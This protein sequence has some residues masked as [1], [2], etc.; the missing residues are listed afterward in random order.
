MQSR[1]WEDK[2]FFVEMRIMK[3]GGKEF[4]FYCG[5]MSVKIWKKREDGGQRSGP[6][7][8]QSNRMRER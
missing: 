7:K 6:K 3:G 5:V 8:S 4:L 1:R 2:P